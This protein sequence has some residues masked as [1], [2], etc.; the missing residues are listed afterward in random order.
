MGF[1]L[2]IIIT[3]FYIISTLVLSIFTFKGFFYFIVDTTI[4]GVFFITGSL[5]KWMLQSWVITGHYHLYVLF[6]FIFVLII[7]LI[8]Y[9]RR[10]LMNITIL[11]KNYKY[12]LNRCK[13]IYQ[14]YYNESSYN[15]EDWCIWSII[16]GQ[17][18]ASV[19]FAHHGAGK[20]T[21]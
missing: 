11:K 16:I 1:F 8:R 2:F 15:S 18:T 4:I 9:K 5:D 20:R 21:Y 14:Y 17:L 7:F 19:T 6:R 12:N 13:Y 10:N 3:K